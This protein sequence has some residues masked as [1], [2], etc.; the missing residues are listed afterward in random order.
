MVVCTPITIYRQYR[1][2]YQISVESEIILY[3]LLDVVGVFAG[4]NKYIIAK[5][6]CFFDTK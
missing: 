2:L 6:K 5:K 4:H 1:I 3:V